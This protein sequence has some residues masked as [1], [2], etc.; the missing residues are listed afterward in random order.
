[1]PKLELS[2]QCGV[3]KALVSRVV[4]HLESVG[5]VE[6]DK[7][8]DSNTRNY[9]ITLTEKGQCFFEERKALRTPNIDGWRKNITIEELRTF[10]KILDKIAGS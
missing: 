3:D 6:K 5:F 9:K 1:M 2:E 7:E 8:A 4:T 10:K